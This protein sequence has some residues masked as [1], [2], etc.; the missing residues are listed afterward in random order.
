MLFGQNSTEYCILVCE[1]DILTQNIIQ[2]TL[3]LGG[4]TTILADNGAAGLELLKTHSVDLII[5]DIVMP[6]M[7][8]L[9]FRRH[10]LADH[11]LSSIPFIFL[12]SKG[13]NHDQIHAL[14]LGAAD[15]L[16]KPVNPQVLVV[17][18]FNSIARQ[19]ELIAMITRDSLTGVLTREAFERSVRQELERICRYNGQ[20]SLVFMDL[21]DFSTV[22]NT[23]GHDVG[24]LLLHNFTQILKKSCRSTDLLGR[25][26][27]EEFLMYMPETDIISGAS[28]V[29]S[30]LQ[31]VARD[32]LPEYTFQV[33]FSAG[34]VGAPK[35]GTDYGTLLKRADEA[36]YRAKYAGK[37]RVYVWDNEFTT[38]EIHANTKRRIIPHR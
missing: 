3:K 23:Y 28:A 1:D 36:M 33:T 26:G 32:T 18:A 24:D 20:G 27:G 35:H 37:N 8:G 38:S 5:S 2:Q 12:T 15:Y 14:E 11:D 21:D 31:K 9:T 29:N 4:F 25:Y 22:N 7:D 19:A 30:M 17:K 10:L 34:I 6:E 13:G 16:I